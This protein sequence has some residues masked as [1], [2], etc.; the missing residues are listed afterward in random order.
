MLLFS[1]RRRCALCGVVATKPF[2]SL[3]IMYRLKFKCLKVSEMLNRDINDIGCRFSA[4]VFFL[5][6]HGVI[7]GVI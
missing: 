3:Y 2:E 1:Y 5:T 6:N 7:L 4:P